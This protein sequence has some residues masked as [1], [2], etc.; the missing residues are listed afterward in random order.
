[1]N[2][3]IDIKIKE[4]FNKLI[5]KYDCKDE[6]QQMILAFQ[7]FKLSSNI[8]C[9]KTLECHHYTMNDLKTCNEYPFKQSFEDVDYQI[10]KYCNNSIKEIKNKK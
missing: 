3:D 10:N 9:E 4:D 2:N 8:L 6:K 5:K 1:M 7:L